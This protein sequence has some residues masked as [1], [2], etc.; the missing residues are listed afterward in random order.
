MNDGTSDHLRNTASGNP[1]QPRVLVV[2]PFM[3]RQGHFAIYPIDLAQGFVTAGAQVTVI[4]PFKAAANTAASGEF[5]I[6]CLEDQRKNFGKRMA[7][8]WRVLQNKPILLCLAWIS[9]NVRRGDYDL[10]YWTDFEPDNQQS[11][12]P[13]S[14]AAGLGLYPHRTA[15]TE[16]HNFSWSK[17]RWQRLF[18]L[19]RLRL[20]RFEMFVQSKKLLEW[21]RL[22]MAWQDKGHYVSHGLW[23]DFADDEKRLTA[24]NTLGISLDA[25]V[26]LVF[27]VQSIRRKEIHTL[28]EAVRGIE[29]HKPLVILFAGM[30]VEDEPHPFDHIDL[31]HK[32]NLI[33]HHHEAFIPIESVKTFFAATDAVWAY[34]GPFIGAS[35][36]LAQAISYGRVPICSGLAEIGEICHQ[37]NV[38]LV[39]PEANVDGV[40]SIVSRFIALSTAEQQDMEK[41][42]REAAGQMTW[43]RICRQTM[44]IMLSHSLNR[45]S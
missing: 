9:L 20:R 14:L 39:S 38:G 17:H 1:R 27:G 32:R 33:V 24:R 36:V 40:R 35:G 26:L 12:W 29:L 4:H 11:I 5:Q 42:T 28:A 21:I 18:R 6:V 44:D 10:V 31:T 22:N 7:H 25:R 15:F 2:G 30:K 34:Y 13:L 16:H 3:H 19:D 37:Y 41:M 43:T 45:P 23:P 8:F